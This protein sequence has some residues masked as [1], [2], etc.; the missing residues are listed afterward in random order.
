MIQI[1][2]GKTKARRR[3]LPMLPE[4]FRVLQERHEEQGRPG[5]GWVFPAGSDSGHLEESS[6]KHC[7]G[8]AIAKLGAASAAYETWRNEGSAGD[9]QDAVIA[10]TR[11]EANY[12]TKHAE[13]IAAGL[14][15]FEPYCLRHTALTRIWPMVELQPCNSWRA[16]HF[17]RTMLM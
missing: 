8:K 4:V 13:V 14:K 16:F 3:M 1:I 5:E 10:A 9:W 15:P 7:H 2:K 12:L 17:S 6:A 11:L